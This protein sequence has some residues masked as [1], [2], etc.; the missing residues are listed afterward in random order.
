[1]VRDTPPGKPYGFISVWHHNVTL[2]YHY[3]DVLPSSKE[4]VKRHT[5]V[6]F[7]IASWSQGFKAE[8]VPSATAAVGLLASC[9][10]G[11]AVDAR[12]RERRMPIRGGK[13]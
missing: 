12:V 3:N 6:A 10:M 11:E 13:S 7:S 8:K 4:S 1:M 5:A 9:C 2:F